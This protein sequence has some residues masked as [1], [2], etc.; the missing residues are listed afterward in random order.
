M[1]NNILCW[2]ENIGL[3]EMA[4]YIKWRERR[5]RISTGCCPALDV[6]FMKSPLAAK[7]KSW[8]LLPSRQPSDGVR[9]DFKLFGDFPHCICL[10]VIIFHNSPI[11]FVTNN[12]KFGMKIIYKNR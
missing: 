9:M 11:R 4:A 10:V 7:A 2:L 12:N 6:D 1:S 5:E 3:A 8:N